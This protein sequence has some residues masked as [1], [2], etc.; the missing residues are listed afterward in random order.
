MTLSPLFSLYNETVNGLVIIRCMRS[1]EVFRNRFKMY[2]TNHLRVQFALAA[3]EK[4]L[5]ILLGLLGTIILIGVMVLGFLIQ[6]HSGESTVFIA[7]NSFELT[8]FSFLWPGFILL[9]FHLLGVDVC[10]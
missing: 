4:W 9:A 10:Y 1:Q 6:A 7:N 8:L 3:A 5:E 2:I